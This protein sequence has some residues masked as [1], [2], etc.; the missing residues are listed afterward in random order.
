[1]IDRGYYEL[2]WEPS[3]SDAGGD[4]DDG[5]QCYGAI[6]P[7]IQW[8]EERD[9]LDI[10]TVVHSPYVNGDEDGTETVSGTHFSIALG[11][12][13]QEEK[14]VFR[15][16]HPFIFLIK[17]NNTKTILFVGRIVGPTSP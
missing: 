13:P 8:A 4:I 10:T 12:G 3:P 11:T 9:N 16:D 14:G 6:I 17:D 7:L 5:T 1:M 15:A 2:C